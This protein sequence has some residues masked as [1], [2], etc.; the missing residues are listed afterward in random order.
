MMIGKDRI[1]ALI[2]HSGAMC[3][4]EGVL[5]WDDE[6]IRCIAVSHRDPHNPM[7]AAGS[8]HAACGIE[9]VSQAMALHGALTSPARERPKRG[10]LAS[11]RDVVLSVARLDTISA[12]LIVEARLLM[13]MDQR[14]LYAFVLSGDGTTLLRGR[15]AAVLDAGP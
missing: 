10:Y 15:A 11:V 5:E 6:S 3:L 1:A 7:R 13:Q 9:Y 4:L 12:D 14:T 2:P 8:L